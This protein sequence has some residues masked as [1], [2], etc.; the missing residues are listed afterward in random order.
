MK[1]DRDFFGEGMTITRMVEGEIV[2]L[3]TLK[4]DIMRRIKRI[5]RM[6]SRRLKYIGER[7]RTQLLRLA[8][9][10]EKMHMPTMAGKCRK[11]AREIRTTRRPRVSVR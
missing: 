11:Q 3:G 10:Y 7:N 1:G 5:A 6:D 9:E 4:P 8:T 2:T